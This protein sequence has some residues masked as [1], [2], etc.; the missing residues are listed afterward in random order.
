MVVVETTTLRAAIECT[1]RP[2]AHAPGCSLVS[3]TV[4]HD[5]IM[6]RTRNCVGEKL[7]LKASSDYSQYQ[8][9]LLSIRVPR[10]ISKRAL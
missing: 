9:R 1:C 8:F 2:H 10:T 7:N 5:S 4:Q 6:N 3:V